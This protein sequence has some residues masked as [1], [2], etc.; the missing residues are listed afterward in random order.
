MKLTY[1][2][3][4][5]N[6]IHYKDDDILCFKN[7]KTQETLL[8]CAN[9]CAVYDYNSRSGKMFIDRDVQFKNILVIYLHE[10]IIHTL[11]FDDLNYKRTFNKTQKEPNIDAEITML[12]SEI[13]ENAVAR[14]KLLELI[15]DARRLE[16]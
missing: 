16:V 5:I 13:I 12:T 9:C 10:D 6:N 15:T 1:E 2:W 8:I 3:D 4:L 11:K 14:L 7:Y